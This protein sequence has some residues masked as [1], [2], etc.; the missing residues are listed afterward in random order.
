MATAIAERHISAREFCDEW[1]RLRRLN[2]LEAD[3]AR[4]VLMQRV[5]KR[6]EALFERYGRTYLESDY[7]KWIA[8]DESGRVLIAPT[9]SEVGHL[10]TQEFEPG[11]FAVRRLNEIGGH[12]MGF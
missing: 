1:Q 8:I 2:S 9:A 11:S 5:D 10:A 4:E 12:R 3:L 6:D 7:G